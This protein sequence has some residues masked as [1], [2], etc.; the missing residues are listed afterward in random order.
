MDSDFVTYEQA[1]ILKE[2]G[3]N[4]PCLGYFYKGNFTP[5]DTYDTGE[6]GGFIPFDTLLNINNPNIISRPL[7]QQAFRWINDELRKFKRDFNVNSSKF[8]VNFDTPQESLDKLLDLLLKIKD[9]KDIGEE[10]RDLIVNSENLD[11]KSTIEDFNSKVQ[12]INELKQRVQRYHDENVSLRAK[13]RSYAKNNNE[14]KTQKDKTKNESEYLNEE[15][16]NLISKN[17]KNV[18]EIEKLKNSVVSLSRIKDKL[19]GDIHMKSNSIVNLEEIIDTLSEKINLLDSKIQSLEDSI[20]E[21][22]RK[23]ADELVEESK[24]TKKFLYFF[25]V[26]NKEMYKFITTASKYYLLAIERGCSE[27]QSR[28]DE[29]KADKRFSKYF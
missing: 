11:S 23:F 20:T 19:E 26:K 16:I 13:I 3:F 4:K 25:R 21:N 27:S 8:F 1:F 22:Y 10:D 7:Y 18:L 2:L 24:K 5:V 17:R 9:S 29:L 14:L 15:V 12:I 6:G 28:L